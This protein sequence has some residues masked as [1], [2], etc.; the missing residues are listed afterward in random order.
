MRKILLLSFL[1]AGCA[2]PVIVER[3]VE[4]KVPVSVPC[5]SGTKPTEPPALR[6][7]L[8]RQDW[9]AMSTDQRERHLAAQALD[10]KVYG[11]QLGVATAGCD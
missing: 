2:K 6:D 8:S 5:I 9:E 10:R 7:R 1:L 4:V 11:D 3:P